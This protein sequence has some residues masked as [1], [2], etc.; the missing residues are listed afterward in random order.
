MAAFN[1]HAKRAAAL[2]KITRRKLACPSQELMNI[3]RMR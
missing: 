1:Y 3:R 2:T